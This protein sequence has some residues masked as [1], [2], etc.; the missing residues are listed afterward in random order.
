MP[1]YRVA[2]DGSLIDKE[3]GEMFIRDPK[4]IACPAAVISDIQPYR[5]PITGEVIGGRAAKRDD[6]KRHDCIDA[7]EV[8]TSFGKR[9]GVKSDKW[10][11][12]LGLPKIG[13]DI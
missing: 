9:R 5:S 1:S 8:N 4:I 2:S 10:A 7:N 6:L 3:T 12:R 13:R 11:N